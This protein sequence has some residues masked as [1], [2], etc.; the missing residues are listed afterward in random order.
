MNSADIIAEARRDL[1]AGR[2]VPNGPNDLVSVDL[3][4]QETRLLPR[5][6]AIL[7]AICE[8]SGRSSLASAILEASHVSKS[9]RAFESL[10]ALGAAHHHHDLLDGHPLGHPL[11]HL[12]VKW[13]S[14]RKGWLEHEWTLEDLDLGQDEPGQV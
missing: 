7:L 3:P 2:A 8:C 10:R 5:H 4:G 11:G 1:E 6:T 13:G 9:P 14:S 12:V